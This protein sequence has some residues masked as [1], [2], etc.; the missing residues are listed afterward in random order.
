[1]FNN[2]VD[3]L[4]L[5]RFIS[6]IIDRGFSG[7]DFFN[8]AASEPIRI[9]EVVDLIVTPMGSKSQILERDTRK[10]SFSI[11][12]DKIRQVFG[13]EPA[14]TRSIIQ[15]YVTENMPVLNRHGGIV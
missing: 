6:W 12:I 11:K 15:R 1:M 10:Q 14:T 2:V 4:E 7:C 13:F 8:L 5:R 3:L 9:R